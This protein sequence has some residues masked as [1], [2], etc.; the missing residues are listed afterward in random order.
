M[1]NIS[2]T[3]YFSSSIEF[4]QTSFFEMHKNGN[5]G[6]KGLRMGIVKINSTSSG[7]L[8]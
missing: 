7:D 2:G 4:I 1:W 5:I 8:T 6:I 3:F